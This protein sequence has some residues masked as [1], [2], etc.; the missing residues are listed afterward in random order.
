[1]R[2]NTCSSREST[3]PRTLARATFLFSRQ[4]FFAFFHFFLKLRLTCQKKGV[5][6]PNLT[7]TRETI[8]RKAS[9]MIKTIAIL[10]GLT[11]VTAAANTLPPTPEAPAV[12]MR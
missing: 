12:E 7:V 11:A 10:L 5:L 4:D 8:E 2:G 1:M 3:R 6:L 9:K